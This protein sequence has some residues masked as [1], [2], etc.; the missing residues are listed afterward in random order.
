MLELATLLFLLPF[1]FFSAELLMTLARRVLSP[2]AFS[3]LCFFS[4]LP[5]H[6]SGLDRLLFR[7]LPFFPSCW[8]TLGP[9][10]RP[11]LLS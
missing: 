5:P 4:P 2:V 9:S 8:T 1:F 11:F 6:V 3:V 7:P 10:D